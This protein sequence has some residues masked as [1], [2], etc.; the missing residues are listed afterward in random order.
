MALKQT[1]FLMI[2]FFS[3][4]LFR[5]TALWIAF[6]PA[7]LLYAF[8]DFIAFL[9]YSVIRYRREIVRKNLINSFPGKQ[10]NEIIKIEK[11]YYRNLADLLVE[12]TQMTYLSRK[13]LANQCT[14]KNSELLDTYF[15]QGKDI[16]AIISHY[17]NWEIGG[18][19]LATQTDYD[20]VALYKPLKNKYFNKWLIKNRTNFGARLV[21]MNDA[22]RYLKNKNGKP[23]FLVVLSDQTPAQST[24]LYWT[25]FLNQETPLFLGAEKMA[26]MLNAVVVYCDM[27]R[28]ERGKYTVEFVNL[29]ENPK[30]TTKNEITECHTRLLEKIIRKK[31]EDWLW[32]HRRWKIK[33]NIA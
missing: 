3:Y 19:A 2:D 6:F 31:P 8:S 30:E 18:F 27:Q 32:S 10:L 24:S 17:A 4:S 1:I 7:V 11:K 23:V 26:K 15:K 29:F 25:N 9:L 5:I 12:T 33:K 28:I 16:I 22:M 21:H 13:Q 20:I 14:F